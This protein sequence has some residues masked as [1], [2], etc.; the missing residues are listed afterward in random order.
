VNVCRN[1]REG[2]TMSAGAAA[3]AATGGLSRTVQVSPALKKFLGVGECSRLE[4]MKRVWVY[5]KDQKLQV[6][7]SGSTLIERCRRRSFV[8]MGNIQCD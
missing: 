8:L 5:I 4:S 3:K 7:L 6:C 2:E 1:L